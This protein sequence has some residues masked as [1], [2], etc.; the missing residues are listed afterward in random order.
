MRIRSGLEMLRFV[1]GVAI[2]L[3]SLRDDKEDT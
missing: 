1:Y 2:I 3:T